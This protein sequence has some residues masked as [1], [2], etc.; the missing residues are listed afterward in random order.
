MNTLHSP[1]PHETKK[2]KSYSKKGDERHGTRAKKQ[3]TPN[4]QNRTKTPQYFTQLG[5]EN[6]NRE[7]N[8]FI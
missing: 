5:Y 2:D 6:H 8:V 3:H 7:A 1:P 4:H